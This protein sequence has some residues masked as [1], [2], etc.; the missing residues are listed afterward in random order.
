MIDHNILDKEISHHK[1]N[2]ILRKKQSKIQLVKYLHV[3]CMPPLTST[4]IKAISNNHF[5]TWLK[6]T[7]NLIK[8]HLPKSIAIVQSYLKLEY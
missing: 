3:A 7:Q 4:F 6:L 8:Q 2:I 5:I 1:A